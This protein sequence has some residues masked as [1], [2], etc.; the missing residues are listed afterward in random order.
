MKT[1]DLYRLIADRP[2]AQLGCFPTPLQSTSRLMVKRDDLTDLALGGN[3]VRKL[4]FF[5]GEALAQRAQVLVT[6]GS[7]HSNHCRLTAAAAARYGLDCR[8]L[9]IGEPDDTCAHNLEGNSLLSAL[10]GARL[11][12]VERATAKEQI[13]EYLAHLARKGTAFYFIEGGGHNITG[14]WGYLDASL[15][16]TTQLDEMGTRPDRL[17]VTCGTGTTQAGLLLGL[18]LLGWSTHVTGVSVARSA[19][20]CRQEIHSIIA[21]FCAIH[22]VSNP[23]SETDIEV[24]ERWIGAGYDDVPVER[25]QLLAEVARRDALLLDPLYTGRT[26]QAAVDYLS[27]VDGPDRGNGDKVLFVH[28][29]GLPGLFVPALQKEMSAAVGKV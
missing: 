11:V 21:E 28:T 19:V 23:V 5:L 17:F 14:M 8:L 12:F 10:L 4:E 27:R 2:R 24:D 18:R 1:A 25:W 22:S 26:M 6:A 16:I 20:R 7:L 29:G 3:K 9:I 13:E 15:E